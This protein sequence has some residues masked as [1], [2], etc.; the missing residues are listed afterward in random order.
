MA[1]MNRTTIPAHIDDR[2]DAIADD[3][4]AVESLGVDVAVALCRD[5]AAA[6]APGLHLYTL[7]R[8]GPVR[9]VWDQLD[10]AS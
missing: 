7:N 2:L 1:A 3:P 4:G 10:G 6:G 5:L 9:R 8:S